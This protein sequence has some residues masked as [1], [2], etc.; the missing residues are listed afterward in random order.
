MKFLR[1]LLAAILGSMIGIFLLFFLMIMI[2]AA[3]GSMSEKE[4]VVKDNSV[5][6]LNFKNEIKDYSDDNP[7][8]NLSFTNLMS[9]N[10]QTLKDILFSIEKAERDDHIKGI[11]LES[12]F[13]RSNFGG[14][15]FLREIRDKLKEFKESGKFVYAYNQL[16]YSQKGY[17]LA[18]VA[19]S[20]FMHPQ[21]NIIF[22]G[23]GGTMSFYP[24][25]LKKVGI[26]PEIIRHGK[27]KAAIEPFMLK[28]MSPENREQTMKYIG[29]LWNDCLSDISEM[30]NI[31]VSELNE[32][33]DAIAVRNPKTALENHFVDALYHQDQF[34]D[35]L[36]Q[37]LGLAATD[38]DKAEIPYISLDK[39]KDVYVKK[40]GKKA[41]KD[42]HIA[43][44]Y[45]EG[46]I[47]DDGAN[48]ITPELI[49]T[50]KKVRDNEKIKAVVLRVNSPGGSALVSEYILREMELLRTQKPLVVSFGNVAA[51]GGYY[52]SCA[53]D[54]IVA[55][56]TTITGSIGVFG[57]FLT[58]KELI[59]DKLGI[60]LDNYGTNEHANFGGGSPLPIGARKLNDFERSI[61]QQSVEDVYDVFISHVAK[62]RKMTKEQVDEIGQGRVWIGKDAKE[63]GL[64]DVM[65]SLFDAVD[66]AK[67]M[68]GI[69]GLANIEEYPKKKDP[70]E[71]LLKDVTGKVK[72]ALLKN[73]LG[74]S[75]QLYKK[76]QEA[77]QYNG[78]QAALPYEIEVR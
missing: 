57:M 15:G 5:L 24:D 52:I 55:E 67:E 48:S 73:E 14:M 30:R 74:E 6:V 66:I 68:A 1:N 11:V 61:V 56:P 63:I 19:D 29:S 36:R 71:T 21:G 12:E 23:F 60:H 32:L 70:I 65:G 17:W 13:I 62:A 45:A 53:A 78:I 41:D 33:A 59:E 69:E 76:T 64:V 49:E 28:K 39:Y 18:S 47:K 75:Y 43:I 27:F 7:F 10:T 8:G 34:T 26:E 58:G 38:K 3:I 40:E 20:V 44:I 42:D 77:L 72:I 37:K 51:S 31:S 35:L 25:M 4:V 54:T 50:I 46:S 9:S 16:G 22:N 2:F